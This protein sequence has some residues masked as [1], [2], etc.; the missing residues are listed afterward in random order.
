[1]AYACA[2]VETVGGVCLCFLCIFQLQWVPADNI[3]TQ[4]YSKYV[5]SY[6][7]HDEDSDW[8]QADAEL[9]TTEKILEDLKPDKDYL[10]CISVA[11]ATRGIGIR[12]PA[13]SVHTDAGN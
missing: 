5:I 10:F 3:R 1:M 8:R 9:S 12:S 11:S 2:L 4:D 13:T 7:E 6:R